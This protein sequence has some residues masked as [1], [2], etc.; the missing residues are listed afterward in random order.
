MRP[1]TSSIPVESQSV[2][3]HVMIGFVRQQYTPISGID[4]QQLA[5]T[6][7]VQLMLQFDSEPDLFEPDDEDLQMLLTDSD[8]LDLLASPS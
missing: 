8:E 5:L 1:F 6:S 2:W 7:Q 4:V 3:T